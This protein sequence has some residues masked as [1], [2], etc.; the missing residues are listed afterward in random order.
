[1]AGFAFVRRVIVFKQMCCLNHLSL[2]TIIFAMGLVK[3]NF[4]CL[5]CILL[6]LGC[7]ERSYG[8]IGWFKSQVSVGEPWLVSGNSGF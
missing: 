7:W 5:W 3:L 1:M 4:I 6:M 2:L 8:L